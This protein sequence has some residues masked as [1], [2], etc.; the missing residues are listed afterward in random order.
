MTFVTYQENVYENQRILIY[1]GLI[2]VP[3]IY[4]GGACVGQELYSKRL[5]NNLD[6]FETQYVPAQTPL[7]F[8]HTLLSDLCTKEIS[9]E[10]QR[11]LVHPGFTKATSIYQ[12]GACAGQKWGR[13]WS[14]NSLE[15]SRI[16]FE[17][18]Q[19]PLTCLHTFLFD[20]CT[21]KIHEK[22]KDF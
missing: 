15:Y 16:E 1:T 10:N 2:K 17:P 11:F 3:P 4:K 22:N 13:K 6:Y 8:F 19:T 21:T 20:L 9:Y 5:D 14:I 18:A 12:G 7:T